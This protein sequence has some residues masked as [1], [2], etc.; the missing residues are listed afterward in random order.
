MA[1]F[2]YKGT[3]SVIGE[4]KGGKSARGFEWQRQTIVVDHQVNEDYTER[5]AVTAGTDMVK[6]L[7][8]MGLAVGD[9]VSMKVKAS[10][11]EWEGRWFSDLEIWKLEIVTKKGQKAKPA[12]APAPEEND[13][14][15]F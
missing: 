6:D 4:V 9:K 2:D 1:T 14:L 11:R 8:D 13:D 7:H 15:P 12:P 5:L 10:S 3:V